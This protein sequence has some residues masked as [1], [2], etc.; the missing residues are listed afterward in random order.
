[1]TH[2][3]VILPLRGLHGG[4]SR[5]ATMLDPMQR[6]TL[7]RSMGRHV[8]SVV[9]DSS[10]DGPVF[11]VTRDPDLDWL[12]ADNQARV[13]VLCQPRSH[14][15]MNA[16]VD[17]GREAA[18]AGGAERVL[19][20]PADLP[21][22]TV[23]DVARML[24][25]PGPVTIAPDKC[26]DGTNALMLSGTA[27]LAHFTFSFGQQ[28]RQRHEE[29]ARRLALDVATFPVPG[30]QVDL[31]TPADWAMLSTE[32]RSRLLDPR[33]AVL[34]SRESAMLVERA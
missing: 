21:R 10:I 5:L 31:D 4:K 25:S 19:V 2:T 11:M 23:A 33:E 9:L 30:F 6:A 16:A 34:A 24:A 13:A 7:V 17:M 8:V 26:G 18:I 15:G 12:V 1:V 28:S 22:L 27:A 32:E 3:A 20:L 29:E 14:P